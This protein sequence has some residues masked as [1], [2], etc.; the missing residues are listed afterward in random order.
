MVHYSLFSFICIYVTLSLLPSP[1]P[2]LALTSSFSLFRYIVVLD[3]LVAPLWDPHTRSF[4]AMIS[5]P[6]FIQTLRMCQIHNHNISLA[7]ITHRSLQEITNSVVGTSSF[8]VTSF[9]TVDV[10]DTVYE[11]CKSLQQ[12][13]SDFSPIINPEDT[14]GDGNILCLLGY[15]DIVHLLGT[16]TYI[17]I[18]S[19][20]HCCD[21]VIL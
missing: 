20:S 9:Q 13:G 7:E 21:S 18:Y 15:Q 4:S 17:Y 2:P 11:M 12:L 1:S 16:S 6:D 5:I 3:A 14:G 8:A 19:Y 10:E